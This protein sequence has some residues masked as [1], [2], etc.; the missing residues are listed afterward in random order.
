MLCTSIIYV[1]V[2][3]PQ[4]P[5]QAR[6][7][8]FGG[9]GG[10]GQIGQILGSFMITRGLSCDHVEFGHFGGGVGGGGSDDPPDLPPPTAL[11]TG[12]HIS[13]QISN[14]HMKDSVVGFIIQTEYMRKRKEKNPKIKDSNLT[15]T[16]TL[17]V[18]IC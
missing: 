15:F 13:I 16:L 10:G 3:Y 1:L 12:L 6:S 18:N 2:H 7:Q 4:D 14:N 17:K 5:H 9:G 8:T 11:A